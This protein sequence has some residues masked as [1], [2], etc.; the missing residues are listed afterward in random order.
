MLP[1]SHRQVCSIDDDIEYHGIEECLLHAHLDSHLQ[2][3]AGTL[4]FYNVTNIYV[5][6]VTTI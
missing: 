1:P 4:G 3:I 5:A 6:G 2:R